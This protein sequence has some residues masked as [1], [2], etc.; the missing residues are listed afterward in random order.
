MFVYSGSERGGTIV[1]MRGSIHFTDDIKELMDQGELINLIVVFYKP[2]ENKLQCYF[3]TSIT[4]EEALAIL[5]KYDCF[6]ENF[7]F[8]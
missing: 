4:E 7:S 3:P 5:R 1:S 8:T 2:R 6:P